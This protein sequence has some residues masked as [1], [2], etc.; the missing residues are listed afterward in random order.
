MR[1]CLGALKAFLGH[2]VED[3]R[4]GSDEEVLTTVSILVVVRHDGEEGEVDFSEAN[5]IFEFK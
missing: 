1:G 2:R 5:T 4:P 3:S